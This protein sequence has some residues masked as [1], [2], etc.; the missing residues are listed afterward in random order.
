MFGKVYFLSEVNFNALN[1]T[2]HLKYFTIPFATVNPLLRSVLLRVNAK[3]F[4]K[5]TECFNA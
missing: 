4:I 2:V 1:N 5:T 3:T